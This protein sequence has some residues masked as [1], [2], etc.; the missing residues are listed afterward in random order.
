MQ[1]TRLPDGEMEH[2][3]FKPG[4]YGRL[5][6]GAKRRDWIWVCT[7]PNGHHGNLSGHE[8]VEHE[9]GTI[10]VSPSILISGGPDGGELWHGFLEHGVWRSCS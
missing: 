8:V 5:K 9:D 2:D 7:T 4:T 3:P 1:G 10:T 6:I